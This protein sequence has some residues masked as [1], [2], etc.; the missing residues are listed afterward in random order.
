MATIRWFLPFTGLSFRPTVRLLFPSPPPSYPLLTSPHL[1]NSSLISQ[2]P[3]RLL[4]SRAVHPKQQ[5]GTLLS[6][7]IFEE[8]EEDEEFEEKHDGDYGSQNEEEKA[9]TIPPTAAQSLNDYRSGG[10][11]PVLT[12][13][14]K[15]E[16]ASY[17][18]SLG[19]KLKCQQVGKSGVTA[20]V[21]ASFLESLEANELLKLKVHSSCPGELV[22][23]IKQLEVATGSVA[24]GQIGRTVILYRPSISKLKAAEKKRQNNVDRKRYNSSYVPSVQS[25]L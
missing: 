20:S 8:D 11:P 21:A 9:S 6:E 15:K 24:V 19:K 5:S 23:V 17:A 1:P 22:D 13:K 16:L 4:C 2:T 18:H 3:R 25:T 10:T 7:R 12:I 14:E